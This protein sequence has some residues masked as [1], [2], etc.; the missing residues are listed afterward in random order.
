M[1]IES[2]TKNLNELDFD[3]QNLHP[4]NFESIIFLSLNSNID[5]TKT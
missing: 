1:S 4:S 5:N 2:I 3:I